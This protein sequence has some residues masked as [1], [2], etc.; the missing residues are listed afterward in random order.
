M[1]KRKHVKKNRPQPWADAN[2]GVKEHAARV[3]KQNDYIIRKLAEYR[4][5]QELENQKRQAQL[6]GSTSVTVDGL[7]K[8]NSSSETV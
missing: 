2:Q 4:A 7:Q 1:P 5:K 8:D 3:R 6:Q